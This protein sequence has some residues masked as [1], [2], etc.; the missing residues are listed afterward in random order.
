MTIEV[1]PHGNDAPVAQEG[2][3]SGNEDTPISG[4]AL[5]LDVDN[6]PDELTY[7]LV[8]ENGGALHGSIVM[9][10]DG[11]F[12]YTPD[13]EFSGTDMIVFRAVDAGGVESNTAVIVITVDPV[14]DFPSGGVQGAPLAYLENQAPVAIDTTLT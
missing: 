6:G 2:S 12:V 13:A 10:A 8:G 4:A 3:A 7:S 5:A 1:D 9:N 14:K 11:T